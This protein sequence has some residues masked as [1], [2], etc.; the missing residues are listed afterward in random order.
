MGLKQ[1]RRGADLIRYVAGFMMV[2]KVIET[3]YGSVVT[4]ISI[5]PLVEQMTKQMPPQSAN[6]PDLSFIMPI[7]MYVGIGFTLLVGLVMFFFYLFSF[8][9]F[10]KMETKSQFS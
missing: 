5:G 9:T 4:Y 1:K 3:A 2:F 7:A 8:L 6:A 10:S